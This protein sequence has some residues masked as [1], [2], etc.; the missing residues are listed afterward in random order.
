MTQDFEMVSG[1]SNT[2]E[3]TITDENAA[4]IDLTGAELFPL[5]QTVLQRF[6][7]E[8]RQSLHG[9]IAESRGCVVGRGIQHHDREP[10]LVGGGH[11]SA[12]RRLHRFSGPGR[13]REERS[14]R[15]ERT[16]RVASGSIP[17]DQEIRRSRPVPGQQ[18]R[19]R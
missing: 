16:G 11:V 9:R 12:F 14:E 8:L 13:V 19:V 15:R 7:V 5:M 10:A 2:L 17:D 3:M 1:D 6:L 18:W 4:A